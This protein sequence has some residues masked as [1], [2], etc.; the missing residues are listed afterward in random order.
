MSARSKLSPW[1]ISVLLLL[2]V[3]WS[4]QQSG[5]GAPDSTAADADSESE[6]ER[7]RKM[8]ELADEIE[9]EAEEIRNMEGTEEEKLDALTRLEEKRQELNDLAESGK[10][11]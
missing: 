5:S 7:T 1:L 9:R 11:N 6:A 3:A 4:C 2:P 8:Q 10:S